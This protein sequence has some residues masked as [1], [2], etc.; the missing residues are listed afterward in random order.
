MFGSIGPTELILIFVIALLVFGPRKL[1]EIGKSVGKAIREFKKASDEIKGRI[2]EEIQAS[3]I[4]DVG[5]DLRAGVESLRSEA[6]GIADA[7]GVTDLR[8]DLKSITDISHPVRGL[9]E[10]LKKG[11]SPD[12]GPAAPATPSVRPDI[13]AAAAAVPDPYADRAETAGAGSQA[14]SFAGTAPGDAPAAQAAAAEPEKLDGSK[15]ETAA[16]RKTAPRVKAKARKRTVKPPV[17]ESAAAPKARRARA[18]AK[19]PAAGAPGTGPDNRSPA[20]TDTPKEPGTHERGEG[21]K[22]S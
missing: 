5:K 6:R 1:P 20:P 11:F 8:K 21:Q 2:E 4:K 14:A 15:L 17:A 22:I 16:G 10:D 9:K 18:S 3:E 7:T 19:A 12:P 13:A